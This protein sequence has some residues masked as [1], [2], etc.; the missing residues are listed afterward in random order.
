MF[1]PARMFEKVMVPLWF[2]ALVPWETYKML[3]SRNPRAHRLTG[4]GLRVAGLGMHPD[5]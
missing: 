2:P 1:K 4:A 5:S 3:R